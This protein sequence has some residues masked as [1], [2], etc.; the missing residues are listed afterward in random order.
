MTT[1][2][3]LTKKGHYVQRGWSLGPMHVTV[4]MRLCELLHK[5]CDK[6]H[7]PECLHFFMYTRRPTLPHSFIP[8]FSQR[9]DKIY[10][11]W[12]HIKAAAHFLF[13]VI[14][15][16]AWH[17]REHTHTHSYT[18]THTHTFKSRCWGGVRQL[19]SI[20]EQKSQGWRDESVGNKRVKRMK[21]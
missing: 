2:D 17:Y 11:L 16:K 18:V 4:C 5:L 21:E 6:L 7:C 8:L 20:R 3:Q 15:N 9:S 12:Q 19:R 10:F 14:P 13:P 1:S